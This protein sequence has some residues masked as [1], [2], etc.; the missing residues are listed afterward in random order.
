MTSCWTR[1]SLLS[2]QCPV[3]EV[4]EEQPIASGSPVGGNGVLELRVTDSL[5]RL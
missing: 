2:A 1:A 4:E 3:D 5:Q